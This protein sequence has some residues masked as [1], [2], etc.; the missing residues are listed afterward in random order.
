VQRSCQAHSGSSEGE[1]QMLARVVRSD[2]AVSRCRRSAGGRR[3]GR[4][5]QHGRLRRRRLGRRSMRDPLRQAG[6]RRP[7]PQ[8]GHDLV[9][10]RAVPLRRV[11]SRRPGGLR[12]Y[13]GRCATALGVRA[14]PAPATR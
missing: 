9:G 3:T 5:R 8:P 14:E 13:G 4:R 10:L 2:K 1:R 11:R 7:G 12:P 6:S